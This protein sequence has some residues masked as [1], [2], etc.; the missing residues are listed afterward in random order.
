MSKLN[1]Y[2]IYDKKAEVFQ[3]PA[4]L[5]NDVFAIRSV[6]AA[7]RDHNSVLSQYPADFQLLKIAEFDT[8]SG[9]LVPLDE[10][11]L[12]TFDGL[13]EKKPAPQAN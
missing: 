2:V 10:T 3:T 12:L 6:C 13:Q 8:V 9:E 4:F 1:L 5:Q 7:V 11:V